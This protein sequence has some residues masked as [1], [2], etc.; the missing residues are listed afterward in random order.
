MNTILWVIG[1][2]SLYAV[3]GV[4]AILVLTNYML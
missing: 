2:I 1:M 3:V 4:T